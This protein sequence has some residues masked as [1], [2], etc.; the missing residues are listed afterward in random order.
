MIDSLLQY[1]RYDFVQNALVAGTIAAVLGAIVGYFV[2]VRNVGFAAHALS[3]IGFTG[4]AAA[5][6]LGV[7][8]LDGM[9]FFTVG[10]GIFMGI[11]GDRV[12]RNDLA[13]GMVLAFALGLGYLFLNLYHSFAGSVTAILFGQIFGVAP[14]QVVEMAILA[15]LSLAGLALFARRL[16]FASTQ[17]RLA[18]ARGLSLTW[19]SVAFMIVL[20]I[21][22][23]LA[24]Q[25]VGILL[26]F[27][28]VIA[29]PGIALRLCRSFWSGM[30]GSIA[31][32]VA[33]TWIGILSACLTNWPP[34]FC[35]ATIFF[36]LYLAVE[37][38]ER[39]F[40]HSP[41]RHHGHHHH[42]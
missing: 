21:S 22:V 8:P 9:L 13:I 40:R 10:A 27:T 30:L 29:P 36:V 37:A 42:H 18:E 32:G 5:V 39:F 1:L 31:L 28:L 35:I 19:L 6:L 17:P 3:H 25:V 7:G 23:A 41:A 34:T 38:R 16:L 14:G 11:L 15:A 12:G 4:A 20:A 24:S 2:I 26:V 33:G